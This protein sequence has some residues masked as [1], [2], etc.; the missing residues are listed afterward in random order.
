M[1][2]MGWPVTVQIG[3]TGGRERVV[4]LIP[5][6]HRRRQQQQVVVEGE[7]ALAVVQLGVQPLLL[8]RTTMHLTKTTVKRLIEVPTNTFG[9]T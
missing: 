7:M 5:Q 6:L 4:L 9:R 3:S 8:R 2:V 1:Y